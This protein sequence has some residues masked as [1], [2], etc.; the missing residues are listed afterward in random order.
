MAKILYA[1]CLGLTQS[2]SAQFI[3]ATCVAARN[4]KKNH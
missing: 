2:I 4:C 1:D 3:L